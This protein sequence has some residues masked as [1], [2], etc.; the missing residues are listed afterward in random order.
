MRDVVAIIPPSAEPVDV[1]PVVGDVIFESY[2]GVGAN[3][4]VMPDNVIPEGTTIG[5]LSFVPP[6][7]P[8]AAWSVY[9]GVPV[10]LV[11][12]RDR[13]R[14]TAQVKLLRTRLGLQD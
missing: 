5:A 2:T 7:F 4:V 13:A 14:V 10:K 12:Q 3:S 11:G 9:A 1:E 6:K 8:F